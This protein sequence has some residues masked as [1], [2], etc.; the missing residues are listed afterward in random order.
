MI[1]LVV[2]DSRSLIELVKT[3]FPPPFF[4]SLH[5]KSIGVAGVCCPGSAAAA[6]TAVADDGLSFHSQRDKR[7]ELNP[8]RWLLLYGRDRALAA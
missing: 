1:F 2:P 7:R 8:F 6:A 4:C 5:L 3:F